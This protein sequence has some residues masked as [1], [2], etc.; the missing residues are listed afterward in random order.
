MSRQ[1]LIFKRR[2]TQQT[3]HNGSLPKALVSLPQTEHLQ[4]FLRRSGETDNF[5]CSRISA[6]ITASGLGCSFR[7]MLPP[8]IAKRGLS[9]K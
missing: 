8:T 9:Y 2:Q 6:G 7:L 1:A 3:Q 5:A 4:S